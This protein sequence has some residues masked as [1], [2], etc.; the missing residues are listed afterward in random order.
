VRTSTAMDSQAWGG[1][2]GVAHCESAA[3]VPGYLSMT[4]WV[5]YLDRIA[6]L[7]RQR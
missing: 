3:L 6:T 4:G 1:V 5:D 7:L 2:P